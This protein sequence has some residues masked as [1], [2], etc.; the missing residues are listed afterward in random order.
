MSFYS[1]V[2]HYASLFWAKIN[3]SFHLAVFSLIAMFEALYALTELFL[4]I[5]RIPHWH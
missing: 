1:K 3:D 2:S 5:L 4:H